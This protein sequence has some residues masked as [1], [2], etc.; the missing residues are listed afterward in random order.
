MEAYS[1]DRRAELLEYC[2]DPRKPPPKV[3][4]QGNIS[5][6][7]YDGNG[8]PARVDMTFDAGSVDRYGDRLTEVS[9]YTVK[10]VH[11]C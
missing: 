2:P 7:H 1:I 5:K 11:L 6:V 10:L 8:A 3:Q 4:A 9:Y